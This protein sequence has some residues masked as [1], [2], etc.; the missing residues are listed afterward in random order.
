LTTATA[1]ASSYLTT[2][3]IS[4][5]TF[6]PSGVGGNGILGN[7]LA[8]TPATIASTVAV[9]S[10]TAAGAVLTTGAATTASANIDTLDRILSNFPAIYSLSMTSAF[11]DERA[12]RRA[13]ATNFFI[14][15]I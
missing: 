8:S 4:P 1:S 10:T 2:V 5:T 11:A 6:A 3:L 15:N 14:L 12:P 9:A 7:A 13:I